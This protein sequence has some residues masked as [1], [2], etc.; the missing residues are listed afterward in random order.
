MKPF[1]S[2]MILGLFLAVAGFA[3][4]FMT[5][6]GSL[7]LNSL[8]VGFAMIIL[9][10]LIFMGGLVAN[11]FRRPTP[12]ELASQDPQN[13]G[14]WHFSRT[15]CLVLAGFFLVLGVAV[16]LNNVLRNAFADNAVVVATI[17]LGG[18]VGCW[19]GNKLLCYLMT[20]PGMR[21]KM[22]RIQDCRSTEDAEVQREVT[23]S[24]NGNNRL[25]RK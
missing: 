20:S 4:L 1:L 18:G 22:Y 25:Y 19:V 16:T 5:Q 7:P 8:F 9:G 17:A 11:A 10:P 12:K 6:G 23:E 2:L 13:P 3:V 24:N 21:A 14:T 15:G